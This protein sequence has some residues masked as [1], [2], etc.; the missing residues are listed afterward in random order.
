[1]TRLFVLRPQPGADRTAD[2]A[3][4]MG[5][6]AHIH[7]LFVARPIEWQPPAVADFDAVLLT[8]AHAVRLSGD[9]LLLYAGL[10]VYAVGQATASALQARGME[11][12]VTGESDG[13]AIAASIAADGRHA[14]LH[15]GGTT[16]APIDVGSLQISHVAV[17][18]MAGADP[19]PD[20]ANLLENDDII[21]VHSPRAGERLSML[22]PPSKRTELHVVAISPAALLACGVGWAS[23]QAAQNPQD[24]EMLALAARL[25]EGRQRQSGKGS[26]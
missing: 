19:A 26:A 22:L 24:D 8:S 12:T 14:V 15:L 11:P 7:P 1:M 5:L 2:K 9:G 17:Y 10:P 13:S 18:T 25:C 23:G 6:D 16:V 4:I 20:L 3:G 21:L